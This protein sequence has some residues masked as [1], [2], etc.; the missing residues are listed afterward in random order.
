MKKSII[1]LIA[2]SLI[3]LITGCTSDFKVDENAVKEV[4][5]KITETIIETV[6]KEAVKK[7]ESKTIS[8]GN[9]KKLNIK[10]VVGNINIETSDVED[11]VIS[12]DI[13]GN[14][15]SKEKTEQLIE[16][17]SY[18]AEKQFDSIVIDTSN[19]DGLIDNETIRTD[20]D[21]SIPPNIETIVVSLNVG[22][23]H[24]EK[25]NGKFE[26]ICDVGNININN[27][28]GFYNLQ[29]DVG[30]IVLN[31][32]A[33]IDRSDY[34]THTGDINL[35]LTDVTN[36]KTITA[37]TDVGNIKVSI[38]ENSSYE[39]IINEFL[40]D[41]KIETNGEGSTKFSLETSVGTID[42]N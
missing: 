6:G 3:I 19:R 10:S 16:N 22:D 1:T 5:D 24:I 32:S 28:I 34:S 35:S 33:A 27:S 21:I 30:N 18:T 15:S 13:S 25:I 29:T 4:S 38:P 8:A 37:K 26:I 11:A 9:L 14:S 17:F 31:N 2:I 23:V 41:E 39:A 40:K 36:A 7:Q 12:I 20:L 42:F